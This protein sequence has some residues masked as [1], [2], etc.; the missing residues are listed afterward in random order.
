MYT[1]FL[2]ELAE[3][4]KLVDAIAKRGND[5]DGVML[6]PYVAGNIPVFLDRRR[7]G[8]FGIE[9]GFAVYESEE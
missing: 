3:L 2:A 7:I 9:D 8:H 4:S 6:L 5:T 1:E